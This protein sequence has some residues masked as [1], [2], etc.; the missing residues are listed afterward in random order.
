M[1][2][3]E[4]LC[5]SLGRIVLLPN[6]R[7]HKVVRT[8]NFVQHHPCMVHLVVVQGDPDRTALGEQ[9]AQ[10][11]QAR[12]HHAQPFVVAQ[13]VVPVHRVGGQPL[14]HDRAV[15]VVVVAPAFVAGVVG[16]VNE[17]QIHRTGVARQQGFQSVQVVAVDDEVAAQVLR[18]NAFAFVGQQRAVRHRQ[19]VVVN[20][21]FAFEDDFGH[22]EKCGWAEVG[23]VGLG[24]VAWKAAPDYRGNPGRTPVKHRPH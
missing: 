18:A 6:A 4:K 12:P 1:V 17:H 19:V 3:T 7:R 5:R 8:K 10:Q 23:V 14:F 16:R 22:G 11:H 21:L 15:D 2:F 13:H 20:V 24:R 9:L